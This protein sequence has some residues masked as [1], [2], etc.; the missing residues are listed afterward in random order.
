MD[1]DDREGASLTAKR[2]HDLIVGTIL[3]A[4]VIEFIICPLA[5]LLAIHLATL[6][7]H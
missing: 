7:L 2:A 6:P 5:K 3:L 1:H 4:G